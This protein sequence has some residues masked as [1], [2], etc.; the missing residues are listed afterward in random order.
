MAD[1]KEKK[2]KTA[3]GFGAMDENQQRELSKRGGRASAQG[4]TSNRGFASMD[5][6]KQRDISSQG[7]RA[8][9]NS[10]TK[11]RRMKSKA[12]EQE[13][14]NTNDINSDIESSQRDLASLKEEEELSSRG[15]TG[16]LSY[17]ETDE[18]EDEG[19]G[20]GNLGRSTKGKGDDEE[21]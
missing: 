8:S 18:D 21:G 16:S 13:L 20:D 9:Q 10:S 12:I 2:G 11:S 15:R 1:E 14:Q 19:L 3:K 5:K 7:G 17:S 4:D 6:N